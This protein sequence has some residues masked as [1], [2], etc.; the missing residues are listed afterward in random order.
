MPETA[1]GIPLPIL[2]R[3]IDTGDHAI[4]EFTGFDLVA[5][6]SGVTGVVLRAFSSD[7]ALAAKPAHTII[8][9]IVEP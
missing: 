2:L 4:A 5:H 1:G 9:L 7:P 3:K 8:W 6:R